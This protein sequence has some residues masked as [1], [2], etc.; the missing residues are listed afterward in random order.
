MKFDWFVVPFLSGL[1][2]VFFFTIIQ[3]I[4]WIKQLSR[5][6][7]ALI[8][9][10]IMSRKFSQALKEIFQES[11]LHRKIF[12]TNPLLGY[13]HASLAFGWF[14]LI[15]LGNIEVKFYS[16]YTINPPYVPIFLNFFEPVVSPHFFSK[17][18]KFLMDLLLLIILSGVALAFLKRFTSR[19][20]GMKR[21]VQHIWFDR[22]SILSLWLIFPTRL[23]AESFSAAI[24]HNGSFLTETIGK[25][26][27][28][29]LPVT[30][31]IYP[32]WWTYSIVLGIF[33]FSLP[34][35]R[36]MHIPTEILLIILR[37]AGIYPSYY[38]HPYHQVEIQSCSR[39]GI[40]VDI[41]QLST[42][43]HQVQPS[44]YLRSLRYDFSHKDQTENCLLCGRCNSA[45]PVGIDTVRIRQHERA[46]TQKFTDVQNTF[47]KNSKNIHEIDVLYFAGCMTHLSPGIK[48]SM[49]T[50]LQESGLNWKMLDEEDT[51]CC[52]R[53]LL[54][55]GQIFAANQVMMQTRMII[56]ESKAKVL[57]TSCPI[58]YKTFKENYRL[59]SEVLHH[60]QWIARL[61]EQN[62]LKIKFQNYKVKYHDPCELGRGMQIYEEPRKILS[63]FSILQRHEYEK[64]K[65]LCC[66]GSLGNVRI[67]L[68]EKKIVA[69]TAIQDININDIDFLITSCP[70]CKK[71]FDS[72]SSVPVL[73]IA[74]FTVL[75][76]EK[77]KNNHP[78]V[79]EK[80]YTVIATSR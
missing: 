47:K 78:L 44:Y 67:S 27:A 39:C 33:F 16:S 43:S 31:L 72:L 65:S 19:H 4:R 38:T 49:R 35:S 11:L 29:F 20:F 52:G 40:C 61:C 41:C 2:F 5:G 51:I 59:N 54:L 55:S 57:V 53:P 64:E 77:S 75:H 8:K 13:M 25:L 58:C 45:C 7:R 24:Y 50:L 18:L 68:R 70:L 60:T 46:L 14:L 56:E 23:V 17:G 9:K 73:D 34:F 37:K 26:L 80:E 74:E 71:S 6:E 79:S 15:V 66:G 32:S 48:K 22:L 62:K 28:S 42:L 12:R 63:L 30:S 21:S 36:Y 1:F 69:N 10:Y 76:L 3:Y